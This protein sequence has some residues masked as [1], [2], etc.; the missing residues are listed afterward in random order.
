L[1]LAAAPDVVCEFMLC[2]PRPGT[3]VH[4]SINNEAAAAQS[5][6]VSL[7]LRCFTLLRFR[8]TAARGTDLEPS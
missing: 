3:R 5:S 7:M 2:N 1:G 6:V 4:R 8:K